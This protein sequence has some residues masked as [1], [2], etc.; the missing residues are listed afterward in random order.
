VLYGPGDPG[1][2]MRMVKAIRTGYFAFPG[3]PTIFKSYGYIY[4]MI[5]SIDF[6]LDSGKNYFV[7][8]YVETPTEPLNN[9][10]A[11][12]KRFVDTRAMTIS[13]PLWILKPVS[14]LIQVLYGFKNPIHPVRVMKAATPTHIVPQAL[15][16]AGFE[17]KYDFEKSLYHW[18]GVA[19]GD[20]GMPDHNRTSVSKITLK[21][22]GETET[23]VAGHTN[24]ISAGSMS[25]ELEQEPA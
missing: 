25:Q 21:K 10:V 15:K 9:L 2:I 12:I 1:N 5:D 22:R 24:R 18:L 16:D 7:Y 4:G 6:V 3:P 17:F 11:I 14:R 23:A 13:I 8:N 19:P 20:F